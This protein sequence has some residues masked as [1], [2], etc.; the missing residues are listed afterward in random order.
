[1]PVLL[2]VNALFFWLGMV[3]SGI[4]LVTS[5]FLGTTATLTL[6]WMLYAWTTPTRLLRT[7]FFRGQATEVE[8]LT[9]SLI[10]PARHETTVLGHTLDQLAL[11][12]HGRVEI[13][14]VTG[15]DDYAT[16]AVAEEAARRHPDLIRV[17]VDYSWPKNKPSALN[18]ALA[19]CTGDIVGIFDAED[20]VA[21]AL[22]P[23]VERCFHHDQADVVQ[24]GVQL[25]NIHSS[26]W[27]LRNCLEYFFWFRSRL[28]FHADN[29]F[30]PLGGN[31]VFVRTSL[32]HSVGGWDDTCLAE[33]CE[34]GVRLSSL[35]ARVS[36]AYD[37][38]L[39]TRE[40]TPST[41][42]GLIKQRT[43]WNQG[44]IQVFRKGVWRNLPT[45]RR[46]AL[47]IYTLLTPFNQAA[48]GLVVPLSI[49]FIIWAQTPVWVAM[50][51]IL[52]LMLLLASVV[53]E[54]LALH[55]FGQMYRIRI[56][57]RDYIRLVAGTFPYQWLLAFAA[58]RAGI[59]ELRDHRGWE[60]TTHS[61]QHLPSKTQQAQ[62]YPI[63]SEVGG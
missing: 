31:T 22:L 11:T 25:M 21:P 19:E 24:G 50:V 1:M 49:V 7:T 34:L 62:K 46:R 56:R 26:W 23:A 42:V 37:P 59:R 3:P 63:T 47:A 5:L 51:G 45:R 44:F 60:K 9:F 15:H 18:T 36:V 12:D 58:L 14:C 40:E 52:P 17:V 2:N 8:P 48:S 33:D 28:H 20:I 55:E 10:V 54:I 35:G 61:G 57:V 43:R 16:T 27:S 32:L 13:I 53:F 41:I 30:I 6:A 29:E 4:V 39:A 38:D